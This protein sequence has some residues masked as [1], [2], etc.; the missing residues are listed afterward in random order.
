MEGASGGQPG[1]RF[2]GPN[3]D[4]ARVSGSLFTGIS[5]LCSAAVRLSGVDGA[6]LAVLSNSTQ[7]RELVYATDAIAQQIDELPFVVGEGPCV[8]AYRA[9][10]NQLWPDL[11][12]GAVAARWPAFTPDA[13]ALG[14]RAAFAFPVPG[15]LRPIG[16]LELYRSTVGVLAGAE[17]ESAL[18]CAVAVGRTLHAN[19]AERIDQAGGVETALDAAGLDNDSPEPDGEF[20][21]AE[22]F[23]AAGMVAVQL[24]VPISEGLDRLRAYSYAQRRS[25]ADVAADIVARRLSLR[26]Q[27]DS[28]E[29]Q[30][31]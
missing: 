4:F 25:I 27:R 18:A 5:T 16:V 23:N 17:Q 6:V 13:L 26:D 30:Q 20:S 2:A 14:V 8:D 24:A 15:V 22:I 31:R 28:T 19:W 7:A 12:L 3:R 21:G 1:D 29:G 11:A 10:R 9:D